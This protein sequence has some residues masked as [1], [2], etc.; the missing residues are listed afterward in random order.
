MMKFDT[1]QQYT[2]HLLKCKKTSDSCNLNLI[3]F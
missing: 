2:H 1:I 3:F